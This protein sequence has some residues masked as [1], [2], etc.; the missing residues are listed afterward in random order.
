MG[1]FLWAAAAV[2]CSFSDHICFN[3][4][5][6]YAVNASEQTPSLTRAWSKSS[7]QQT[8]PQTNNDQSYELAA[9]GTKAFRSSSWVSCFSL[10]M[11]VCHLRASVPFPLNSHRINGETWERRENHHPNR[12]VYHGKVLIQGFQDELLHQRTQTYPRGISSCH[13]VPLPPIN[14]GLWGSRPH[15][16]MIVTGR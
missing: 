10:K 3:H 6:L 14:K 13:G 7:K 4:Q 2:I 11:Q 1:I 16:D 9:G 15:I 12:S 8:P 5:V